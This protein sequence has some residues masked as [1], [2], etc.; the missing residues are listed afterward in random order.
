M[1]TYKLYYFPIKGLG[2]I[3]R[4]IFAAA[5]KKFEDIRFFYIN[6]YILYKYIAIK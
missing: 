4:Q 3:P 5:D 6:T 2:E 1:A